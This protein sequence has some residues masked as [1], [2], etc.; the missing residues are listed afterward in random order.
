[1]YGYH[2][3]HNTIC[4]SSNI[5]IWIFTKAFPM[6]KYPYTDLFWTILFS[7]RSLPMG[8][9]YAAILQMPRAAALWTMFSQLSH[10]AASEMADNSFELLCY[11]HSQVHGT[12]ICTFHEDIRCKLRI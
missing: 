9:N 1:M 12:Q 3:P 10:G 6:C 8:Q 11:P 2:I 4:Q 7:P 5:H